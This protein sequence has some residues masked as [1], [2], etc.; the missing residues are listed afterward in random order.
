M[1]KSTFG[2][3]A[4]AVALAVFAA[5]QAADAQIRFGVKAGPSFPMGEEL[6]EFVEASTGWHVGGLVDVGLPLLPVGGRLEALYQRLPS[7]HFG[8]H[9]TVAGIANARLG[10][11]GFGLLP[12]RPYLIGGVGFYGTRLGEDVAHGPGA[13]HGSDDFDV[14]IGFNAGV[15]VSLG[16]AILNAFA[17]ARIHVLPDHQQLFVPLSI[18]IRF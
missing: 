18:G 6:T 11:P 13:D 5:P 10:I 4:A 14:D 16:L 1:R 9:E 8:H 15:G 3:A 7:D 12:V 2:W 17:E